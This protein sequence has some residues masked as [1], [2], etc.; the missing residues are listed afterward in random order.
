M[1]RR[2]L[3]VRA[4]A[5]VARA[6]DKL[7]PRAQL[8]L[9]GGRPV[10]VDGQTLDSGVQLMLKLRERLGE[11]PPASLSVAEGRAFTTREAQ[12]AA[13]PR[14]EPVAAVRDLTVAGADG[15]LKARLY[16]TPERGGPHPLLV[17]LHGGGF[18]VGDVET[19]DAPCRTLCRWGG[20]DVLSVEYRLSPEVPFPVAH[21]DTLAAWRWA[22]EHAAGLGSDPARVAVGGD[23]AGGNL[24]ASLAQAVR[25]GV[26]PAPALQLLIYPATDG[27]TPRRSHELFSDG[28]FL[29]SE[30]IQWYLGHAFP[31]GD[32][33]DVRRSPLLADDLTGLAPAIVATAGFDPL[34]DEGE[35]YAHA[36][37]EAGVPVVL[38]RFESL[39]HGF[40]NSGA[41]NRASQAAIHEIAGMVRALLAVGEDLDAARAGEDGRG[42]EHV[43][44]R[45]RDAA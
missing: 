14:P 7:P 36:L 25:G 41:V 29:T 6:L 32:A 18:V 39:F 26:A 3:E 4:S 16:S 10:V 28:F 33:S 5:A 30:L 43:G 13:P 42:V 21:D 24:A 35:A 11:P 9:A 17:F 45:H 22:C 23:S 1:P 40:L 27:V 44:P 19:H 20:V 2:S 15:P 31:D 38:R 12:I 8:R 37:R 34:R